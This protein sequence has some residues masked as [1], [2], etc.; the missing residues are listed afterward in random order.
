MKSPSLRPVTPNNRIEILDIWRG[1]AVFGIFV[2]NIEIMNA[3]F[4]NQDIFYEQSPGRFDA[5]IQ[6]GLQLF[7]YTKFFPIFSFLFGMGIAMQLE[8]LKMQKTNP[9]FMLKRMLI[10]FV[11]GMLHILVLWGGDVIHLY[12]ILGIFICLLYQLNTKYLL[13]FAIFILAFPFYDVIAEYF[14]PFINYSPDKYLEGYNFEK[15]TQ[16]LRNGNYTEALNFRVLE[17]F[18]NLT[19]LLVFLAPIAFSMM[20]LGAAFVRSC[21]LLGLKDFI[22]KS[23]NAFIWLVILTN[24]YRLIFLFILP[25]FDIYKDD[26][27]NPIWLKLMVICDTLFGLFYMWF[28]AWLWFT[29]KLTV[30]LKRFQPVGKT[31]LSNYILQSLI[32]VIIFSGI[33]FSMYQ[34]MSLLE[35]FITA[36][37]CF[38]LQIMLSKLWLKYFKF[39]PLEWCWRCL[40]Y[41]RLFSIKR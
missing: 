24:V 31:A 27:F 18:A 23:K 29:G 20:L 22:L 10:L 13:L 33:G 19:V 37:V 16:I 4:M 9:I 3:V 25:N 39:G 32:G 8:K 28:I 41:G 26:F 30:F 38:I 40:S 1:F 34:K 2:V 21:K 6:R 35:C 14:F 5:L 12:A 17:Y 15:V 36:T 7:F 11:I